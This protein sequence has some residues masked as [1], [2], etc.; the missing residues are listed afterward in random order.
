MT[1]TKSVP[2]PQAKAQRQA[3]EPIA[4]PI[5]DDIVQDMLAIVLALAPNFSR[6][7]AE[8]VDAQV[9]D[10]WGG[11]RPYIARRRGEGRSARNAAIRRDYLAGERMGLLERRYGLSERQLLRIIKSPN[12]A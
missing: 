12:A 7:L 10:R 6:A 5:T 11:D 9:R 8:Q 1:A 3:A 2:R 4:T